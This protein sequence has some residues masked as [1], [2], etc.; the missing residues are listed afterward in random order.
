MKKILATVLLCAVLLSTLTITGFAFSGEIGN[1]TVPKLGCTDTITIDGDI[2]SE[3]FWSAGVTST[4]DENTSVTAWNYRARI[5]T[6]SELSFV[7]SNEGLYFAAYTYDDTPVTSTGHDMHAITGEDNCKEDH[8]FNGDTVILTIDPLQTM[9]YSYSDGTDY[10]RTPPAWYCFTLMEDGSTGVYR[11][12]MGENSGDVSDVITAAAQKTANNYWTLEAFI[13][14][15]EIAESFSIITEGN[16]DFD[17]EAFAASKAVHSAKVIYMNRYAYDQHDGTDYSGMFLGYPDTGTIVTICRNYTVSDKIPGTSYNGTDGNPEQ[18][19][20]SGI[21]LNLVDNTTD[22]ALHIAAEEPVVVESTCTKQGHST[23]YCTRCKE[24]LEREY[25]ELKPHNYA[26]SNASTGQQKCVD[27]TKTAGAVLNG[28]GYD[29]FEQAVADALEGDTV[30]AFASRTFESTL[31]IPAAITL[32][33]N[34]KTFK[35]ESGPVFSITGD[36]T[37]MSSSGTSK[38]VGNGVDPAVVISSANVTIDGGRFNGSGA[39]TFEVDPN[40]SLV[41]NDGQF[42]S[43]G[44]AGYVDTLFN[45]QELN[46]TVNGGK[47]RQWDPVDYLSTCRIS[48]PA[49]DETDAYYE[50]TVSIAHTPS[51]IIEEKEATCTEDGYYRE[52]CANCTGYSA[53]SIIEALGHTEGEEQ[54]K[55]ATCTEDGFRKVE[56]T[57]CNELVVDEVIY[58]TGHTESE[59][60]Y[61]EADCL[62]DGVEFTYCLTCGETLYE[63]VT[64]PALGHSYKLT[65]IA[66]TCTEDGTHTFVCA[67]GDTLTYTVPALGHSFGEWVENGD[68]TRSREC[69]VCDAVESEAIPATVATEGLV[70]NINN[71][72]GARDF[73][74]GKGVCTTY[75]EVKNNGVFRATTNKFGETGSYS[76]KVSEPGVYTILVRYADGTP[77]AYYQVTVTADVAP[78]ITANRLDVTVTNLDDIYV[79]RYAPGVYTTSREVKY[80]EGCRNA[81]ARAINGADSFTFTCPEAGVYTVVVQ[82]NS[83]LIVVETITVE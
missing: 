35:S 60:Q 59:M 78:E 6:T 62:S 51:G 8:G 83:G 5:I 56:C 25:L 47:F 28:V 73:L 58:A 66:P 32:D 15:T 9:T 45:A 3:E 69:T 18:V 27:C 54:Y 76:Y 19:R 68:G 21:Y 1:I 49:Y 26:V 67:C 50:Y 75:R 40:S 44:D 36:V 42:R 63:S 53:E 14:W 46:L 55:A 80:A 22:D 79:I 17:A 2:S 70:I 52:K 31:T 7:Y 39:Y 33:L 77:D 16:Y 11:A 10:S 20:T 72:D 43:N 34:G 74:I 37:F 71:L 4:M 12:R 30:K 41:I 82:Y 24:I 65:S 48:T 81:T 23:I 64:T 61:I 13:P 57:V 38:V 29:L